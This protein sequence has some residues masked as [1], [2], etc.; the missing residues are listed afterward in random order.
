[1]WRFLPDFA[2]ADYASIARLQRLAL[3][4]VFRHCGFQAAFASTPRTFPFDFLQGWAKGG[5]LA[6][7]IGAANAEN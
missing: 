5:W 3:R 2:S 4:F 1:V 7:I 6:E